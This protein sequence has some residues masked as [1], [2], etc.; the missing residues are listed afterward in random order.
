MGGCPIPGHPRCSVL[1]TLLGLP[2]LSPW[3]GGCQ[4]GPASP[5]GERWLPCW[6]GARRR[7]RAAS[8]LVPDTGPAPNAPPGHVSARRRLKTNQVW[9]H[10]AAPGRLIRPQGL[11]G[12]GRCWHLL[13]VSPVTLPGEAPPSR[14]R[15]RRWAGTELAAGR[16]RAGPGGGSRAPRRA[17]GQPGRD[18]PCSPARAR[19]WHPPWCS[20]G[21]SPWAPPCTLLCLVAAPV[22][23]GV[24]WGQ[25]KPCAVPE[26]GQPL[27]WLTVVTQSRVPLAA[28][29]VPAPPCAAVGLP[30]AVGQSWGRRGVPVRGQPAPA[31][32]VPGRGWDPS[33]VP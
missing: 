26:P 27:A 10:V 3:G 1:P 7:R 17:Q 32:G 29:S 21:R 12:P 20:P 2:A 24:F 11:R 6:P 19:G 16:H 5:A 9:G 28:S 15:C 25:G 30:G 33:A 8:I 22:L 14:W 13:R 31:T 4:P 18:G 23:C